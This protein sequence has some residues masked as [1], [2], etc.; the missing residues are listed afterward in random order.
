MRSLPLC[1]SVSRLSVKVLSPAG[2]LRFVSEVCLVRFVFSAGWVYIVGLRWDLGVLRN[3]LFGS[4]NLLWWCLRVLMLFV[5]RVLPRSSCPRP[6]CGSRGPS[7]TCPCPPYYKFLSPSLASWLCQSWGP[8][9]HDDDQ[10][11][12]GRKANVLRWNLATTWTLW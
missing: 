7:C 3:C 9:S 5:L 11:S 1:Q 8:P 2:N 10:W 12:G 4:E 6:Q